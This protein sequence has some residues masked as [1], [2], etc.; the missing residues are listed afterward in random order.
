M[1]N[2]ATDRKLADLGGDPIRTSTMNDP[3]LQAKFAE[4]PFLSSSSS[5][6]EPIGV[7]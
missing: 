7:R 2:K 6:P 1:T 3:E 4:Y 5:A